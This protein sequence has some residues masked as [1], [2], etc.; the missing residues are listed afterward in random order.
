MGIPDPERDPQFYEGVPMRRLVAFVIDFVVILILWVVMVFLGFLFTVLTMGLGGPIA[1]LMATLTGVVYR[2]LMLAQRS[3]T[4]GMILTGV[5][6]RD[7]NGDKVS[8]GLG[9][10]HTLG[11]TVTLYFFPL[12]IIGWILMATSPHKRLLHDLICGTVVINRPA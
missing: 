5:E 1:V 6:V 10:L 3:A 9:L 11:Y 8:P 4:L 2:W 12:M 7:G